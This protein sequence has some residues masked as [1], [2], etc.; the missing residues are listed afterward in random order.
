MLIEQ[1]WGDFKIEAEIK[2]TKTGKKIENQWNEL[3][4]YKLKKTDKSIAKLAPKD[5]N[6]RDENEKIITD[7]NEI[8][9]AIRAYIYI[10]PNWKA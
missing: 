1:M 7:T 3:I 10:L 8:Q 2:K 9:R 4:F 6:I 5:Q